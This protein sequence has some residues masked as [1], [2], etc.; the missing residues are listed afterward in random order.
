MTSNPFYSYMSERIDECI[1]A[2]RANVLPP[3]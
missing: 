1:G 3:P 2:R